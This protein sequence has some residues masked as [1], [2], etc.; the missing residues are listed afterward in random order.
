MSEH[1]S[2]QVVKDVNL[3]AVNLLAVNLFNDNVLKTQNDYQ[4]LHNFSNYDSEINESIAKYL[5]QLS[6]LQQK[7]IKIAHMHLGTSFNILKSNGYIDWKK[8]SN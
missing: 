7:A 8:I 4:N 1:N 6:P 3:L 2:L 5:A